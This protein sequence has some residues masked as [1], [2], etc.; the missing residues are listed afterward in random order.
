MNNLSALEVFLLMIYFPVYRVHCRPNSF[1]NTA[2][3]KTS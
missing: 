3:G 2:R 1:L